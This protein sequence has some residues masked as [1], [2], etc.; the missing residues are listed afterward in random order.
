[1]ASDFKKG[2]HSEQNCFSV[3]KLAKELPFSVANCHK[4]KRYNLSVSKI[5]VSSACPVPN[6][7]PQ[8]PVQFEENLLR[9][10]MFVVVSPPDND[11]VQISD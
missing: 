7:P 11:T 1:M 5:V 9:T 6:V 3:G 8:Y 4:Q 10:G 2:K